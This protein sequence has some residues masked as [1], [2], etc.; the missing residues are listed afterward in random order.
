MNKQKR[1][2]ALL[3]T[4]ISVSV[5]T[6][7]LALVSLLIIAAIPFQSTSPGDTFF[8]NVARFVFFHPVLSFFSFMIAVTIL[9]VLKKPFERFLKRNSLDEK[10]DELFSVD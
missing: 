2:N 1:K 9:S 7:F 6:I 10:L 8:E 4:L 3:L 5:V